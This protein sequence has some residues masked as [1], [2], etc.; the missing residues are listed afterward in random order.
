MYES[1]R[2]GR[3]GVGVGVGVGGR[4]EPSY[5]VQA[6]RNLAAVDVDDVAVPDLLSELVD[7]DTA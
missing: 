1:V 6:V 4:T 3:V 5:Y 7:A 2:F